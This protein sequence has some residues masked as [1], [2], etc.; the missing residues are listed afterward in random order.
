MPGHG[1]SLRIASREVGDPADEN[2]NAAVEIP[3]VEVVRAGGLALLCL[4]GPRLVWIPYPDILPGS[5]VSPLA[6]RGL[7]RLPRRVARTLGLLPR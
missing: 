2:P 1:R 5:E 4:I 3:R 7:L 6:R